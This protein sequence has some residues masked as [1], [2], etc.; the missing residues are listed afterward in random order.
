[1]HKVKKAGWKVNDEDYQPV[2]NFKDAAK[3]LKDSAK[4]TNQAA[5]NLVGA[6]RGQVHDVVLAASEYT[7]DYEN[8]VDAGL[9]VAAHSSGQDRADVVQQMN[10]V[11]KVIKGGTH[12]D[13]VKSVKEVVT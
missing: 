1:M 5:G 10:N 11:A 8:L 6:L 3:R 12:F 2:G 7:T 13:P 4:D 9:N